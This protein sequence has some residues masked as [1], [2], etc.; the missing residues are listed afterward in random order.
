[1]AVAISAPRVVATAAH[2]H[3]VVIFVAGHRAWLSRRVGS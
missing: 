1:M 2:P 3:R